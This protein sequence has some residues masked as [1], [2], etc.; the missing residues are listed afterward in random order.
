M[1]HMRQY[2]VVDG[3]STKRRMAV[4]TPI[5]IDAY[6]VNLHVSNTDPLTQKCYDIDPDFQRHLV[7]TSEWHNNLISHLVFHG[8][9]NPLIYHT[10]KRGKLRYFENLDGKQRSSALHCFM[11]DK[12]RFQNTKTFP[13][14]HDDFVNQLMDECSGRYYSEWPE[15]YRSHFDTLTIDVCVYP[16]EMSETMKADFFADLQN[17]VSASCGEVINTLR[18]KKV[19]KLLKDAMAKYNLKKIWKT[20][21]IRQ[22]DLLTFANLAYIYF[23]NPETTRDPV[24]EDIIDWVATEGNNIDDAKFTEFTACVYKTLDFLHSLDIPYKSAKNTIIGAFLMFTPHRSVPET[25]L[26]KIKTKY[27][28]T[29]TLVWPEIQGKPDQGWRRY[30]YLTTVYV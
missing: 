16:F 17:S 13:H 6:I 21:S 2:K 28:T 30:T 12:F 25:T 14:P 1:F 19:V 3:N 4:T 26:D 24:N 7:T 23:K 15:E 10:V 27:E 5:R 18:Y 29:K 20:P 11:N 8:Q 22:T 9:L